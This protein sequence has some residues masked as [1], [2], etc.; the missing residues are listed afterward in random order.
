[1]TLRELINLVKYKTDKG[2]YNQAIADTNAFVNKMVSLGTKMTLAITT[3]FVLGFRKLLQSTSFFEQIRVS[4]ETILGSIDKAR[5]KIS[6]LSQFAARTPFTIPGVF[7]ASKQLLAMGIE[8]DKLLPTLKSLGDVSAGLSV[9]LMRIAHNFGQVRAQGKLTGRE[10]RDFAVAGIPLLEVLAKIKD[11]TPEVIRSM[12]RKGG[13]SFA[14]VEEAFIS[15]TSEGGK[16]FNLMFKQSKTLGG[17]WSNFLDLI[18][19]SAKELGT[20]LLPYLKRFLGMLINLL[21]RFNN[22]NKE[23][24]VIIFS[25]TAFLALIGPLMLGLAGL[26]RLGMFTANTFKLIGLMATRAGTSVLIFQAKM[27]AGALAI[28]GAITTLLL[29]IEDVYG[30]FTG[31]KSFIGRF[32]PSPDKLKSSLS[33]FFKPITDLIDEYKD[34]FSDIFK[35]GVNAE[36]LGKAFA[37]AIIGVLDIGSEVFATFLEFIINAITHPRTVEAVKKLLKEA[38]NGLGEFITE[39]FKSIFPKGAVKDGKISFFGAVQKAL[40]G[41]PQRNS[42]GRSQ[43]LPSDSQVKTIQK[44]NELFPTIAQFLKTEDIPYLDTLRQLGKL[45]STKEGLFGA[46]T[47]DRNIN[48]KVDSIP[49]TV[50]Q[51]TT[52]EQNEAI[53]KQVEEIAKPVMKA[54]I[55]D[56][57]NNVSN[58]IPVGD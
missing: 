5:E 15:M 32:L 4:F 14:D 29:L 58:S 10:L 38:I 34:K 50:P 23:M 27:L 48:V 51:G 33:K 44:L 42:G 11:V 36:S 1:M 41:E 28:I 35:G 40:G 47:G 19:L 49:V 17:M 12:M 37:T 39:F 46:L 30:Y 57:M 56:T 24:K 26:I 43:F 31:K 55:T 22:L 52:E 6:Q 45:P 21:D 25:F 2:S 9:P 8:S 53:K 20:V 7:E 13:I 3:P 18:T 54:V 16:F